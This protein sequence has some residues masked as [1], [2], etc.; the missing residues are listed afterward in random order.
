MKRWVVQKAG[1]RKENALK[2]GTAGFNI[3]R[4][5]LD[6]GLRI[7]FDKELGKEEDKANG[8]VRYQVNPT[9]NWGPMARAGPPTSKPPQAES[10]GSENKKRVRSTVAW[11]G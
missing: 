4:K 7:V 5:P 3:M 1:A 10:E 8:I 2:E 11:V 9:A 6:E